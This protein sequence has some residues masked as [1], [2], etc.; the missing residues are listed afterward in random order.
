MI[1]AINGLDEA[2]YSKRLTQ[3]RIWFW[4]FHCTCYCCFVIFFLDIYVY[5]VYAVVFPNS[6][7]TE[8]SLLYCG[9]YYIFSYNTPVKIHKM[10]NSRD[11]LFENRKL[12]AS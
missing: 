11:Y 9:T 8:H 5:A 3:P 6:L 2:N 10:K 7:F 12:R 4:S 1:C